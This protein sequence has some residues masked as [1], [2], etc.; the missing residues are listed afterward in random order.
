M[1]T[2]NIWSELT[3]GGTKYAATIA[4]VK[5]AKMYDPNPT[6]ANVAVIIIPAITEFIMMS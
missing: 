5:A 4:V 6:V 3:I 2:G 1:Y